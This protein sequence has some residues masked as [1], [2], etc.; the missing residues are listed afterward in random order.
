MAPNQNG[1]IAKSTN[2]ESEGT[3]LINRSERIIVSSKKPLM[4]KFINLNFYPDWKQKDRPNKKP[5]ER[6][7]GEKPYKLEI[8]WLNVVA[9]IYLH[10]GAVYAFT[11]PTKLSTVVI[12]KSNKRF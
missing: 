12:C 4:K 6:K 5:Y 9:F 1:M 7:P 2:D 3:T 10:F 11:Y 8:V